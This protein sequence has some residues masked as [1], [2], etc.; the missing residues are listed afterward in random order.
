MRARK[1]KKKKKNSLSVRAGARLRKKAVL[2]AVGWYG[3]RVR[4]LCVV[5]GY[6][7]VR[8]TVPVL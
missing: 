6:S 2:A 4:S 3:L 7:S 5:L 8:T 1:E